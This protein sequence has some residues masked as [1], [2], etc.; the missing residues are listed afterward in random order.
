MTSDS[1]DAPV[2]SIVAPMFVHFAVLSLMAIG[3]GVVMVA[4]EMQRYVVDSHH[5]ITAEQFSAAFALGRRRIPLVTPPSP[6][7]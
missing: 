5:W 4:P 2:W 7:T 3:G 1:A 6:V